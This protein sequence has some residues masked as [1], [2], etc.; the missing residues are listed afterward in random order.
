[1]PICIAP[2]RGVEDGRFM[3]EYNWIHD[4]FEAAVTRIL[5]EVGYLLVPEDLPYIQ[6]LRDSLPRLY[7]PLT[8]LRDAFLLRSGA[9]REQAHALLTAEF[10]MRILDALE[11]RHTP[12]RATIV[13]SL[14]E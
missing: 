12:A 7:E 6:G 13:P 14:G 9:S 1:M 4:V 11:S 8:D 3:E 5:E 10:T 2:A